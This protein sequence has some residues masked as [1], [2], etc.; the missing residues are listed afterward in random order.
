MAK[1]TMN[2][3]GRDSPRQAEFAPPKKRNT[4]PKWM[5]I[6][7]GALF[8]AMFTGLVVTTTLLISQTNRSEAL[9]RE[10]AQAL[11]E[12][13]LP[14]L[15]N[16]VTRQEVSLLQSGDTVETPGLAD[17]VQI[18]DPQVTP[19]VQPPKS[20]EVAAVTR[21][22]LGLGAEHRYRVP[23]CVDNL[24]TLVKITTVRF[25]LG[26]DVPSQTDM[27]RARNI[28][29]AVATCDEVKVIV[30]GHSDR[31]G[32]A[33]LNM[34]LSWFRAQSV[35]DQLQREGFDIS[36]M[37]PRGFGA[38]RPINLSGTISGEAVNRRVQFALAPRRAPVQVSE[39]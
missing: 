33:D 19:V 14:E 36:A 21:P 10:I 15:A 32:N 1:L 39:N 13:A 11:D 23:S 24:D 9:A 28:A 37:Q 18:A 3:P 27:I 2:T 7:G 5:M 34:R 26:S 38:T 25:P 22:K 16:T 31:R 4:I 17:P 6:S 8:L 30:E 12:P 20:V 35:I 29:T